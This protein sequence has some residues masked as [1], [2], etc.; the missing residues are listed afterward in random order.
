[1]TVTRKEDQLDLIESWG[2]NAPDFGLDDLCIDDVPVIGRSN[3]RSDYIYVPF[4]GPST[5]QIYAGVHWRKRQKQADAGH[6]AVQGIKLAP[7]QKPVRLTF[8][9]IIGK[10]GRARDCSNYSYTAKLIEDG[11]VKAGILKD[12]TSEYVKGFEIAEPHIDR[13][14]DSGMWVY[15]EEVSEWNRPRWLQDGNRYPWEK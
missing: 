14:Q 7:Y 10:G 3:R 8:I 2:S 5:N 13:T 1:M 6:A 9:P 12:D 15:I 4:M 11:L